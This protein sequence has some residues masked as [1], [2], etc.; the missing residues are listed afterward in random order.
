MKINKFFVLPNLNNFQSKFK[1]H[2]CFF[3]LQQRQNSTNDCIVAIQEEITESIS[4]A[5][6]EWRKHSRKRSAILRIIKQLKETYL[7]LF[8]I[9]NSCDFIEVEKDVSK[10]IRRWQKAMIF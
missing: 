3:S 1:L 2:I 6:R 5:L 10:L 8:R 7:K 4:F 9:Q